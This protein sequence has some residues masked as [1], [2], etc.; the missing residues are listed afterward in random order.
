MLHL[1]KFNKTENS[2]A[3]IL[4]YRFFHLTRRKKNLKHQEELMTYSNLR[5]TQSG[6]SNDEYAE[7]NVT[8]LAKGG[9]S[10]GMLFIFCQRRRISNREKI[11]DCD[12]IW[13][14][15]LSTFKQI[16]HEKCY[17]PFFFSGEIPSGSEYAV[18]SNT[19]IEY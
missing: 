19:A 4:F 6:P 8:E 14:L 13:C 3:D 7:L 18:Y 9:S 5:R 16:L 10:K 1:Q 15:F 17:L 12:I 11:F 2:Q